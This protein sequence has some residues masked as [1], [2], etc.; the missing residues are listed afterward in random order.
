MFCPKCGSVLL[1]KKEGSKRTLV[2]SCGYKSSN[3]EGVK[4]TETMVKKEKDVEVIDKKI[5]ILPKTK[6]ECEKCG[7]K[8]AFIFRSSRLFGSVVRRHPS[9]LV[10]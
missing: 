9:L 6:A 1:P 5:N 8:V 7:H 2:C 4:I 3:I 10:G